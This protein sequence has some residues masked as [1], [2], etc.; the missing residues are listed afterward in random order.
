MVL[1]IYKYFFSL[2]DIKSV[3]LD[4]YFYSSGP[5]EGSLK[6]FNLEN[7]DKLTLASENCFENFPHAKKV[8]LKDVK[9]EVK[10]SY[11]YLGN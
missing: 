4:E 5:T 3:E 1:C 9:I 10:A 7:L 6:H 11:K 8:N 2:K